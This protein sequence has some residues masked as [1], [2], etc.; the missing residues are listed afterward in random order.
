M[1]KKWSYLQSIDEITVGRYF[2]Y[3]I[4]ALDLFRKWLEFMNDSGMKV[5]EIGS[6]SGFFTD[7]LLT[8]FPEIELTCLEPDE[9]FVEKLKRRFGK[10]ITIIIDEVETM[11]IEKNTF[12]VVI[13]HIVIHNL[14]NPIVA[15]EQMK[16]VTKTN[17]RIV[18]IEPLP[19][20]RNY[21]PSQEVTDAFD[22][23]NKARIHKCIQRAKTYAIEGSVNPWNNCYPRFYKEISLTNINNYGWTSVFTLSDN[24]YDY[25]EKKKWLKMRTQLI[26]NSK[27]QT[28]K[29]L[30]EA[31]EAKENIEAAFRVISAYFEKLNNASKEEMLGL[32]EQEIVHRIIVIGQKID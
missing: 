11:K 2:E 14:A 6:G 5:L 24:R 17:G 32:H 30:L 29:I 19:A 12:D 20:S 8:L 7:F 9:V 26:E 18:V 27:E 21:Y 22:F 16:R 31:G 25:L 15:L 28:A 23:L 1:I 10:K 13:S 4:D 3:D